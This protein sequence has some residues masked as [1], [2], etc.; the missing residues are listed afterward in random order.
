MQGYSKAG[1]I[2]ILVDF[3]P[4]PWKFLPGSRINKEFHII[5]QGLYNSKVP[6]NAELVLNPLLFYLLIV[7]AKTTYE[8]VGHIWQLY[9]NHVKIDATSLVSHVNSQRSRTARLK[10]RRSFCK[11]KHSLATQ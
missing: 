9:K 8:V 10:P 1:Y 4:R 6:D 5:G 3:P 11:A 7:V 2:A